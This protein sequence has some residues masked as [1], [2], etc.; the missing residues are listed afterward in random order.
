MEPA[1][2]NFLQIIFIF[3]KFQEKLS[4]LAGISY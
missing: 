2:L 1:L 3:I 4:K